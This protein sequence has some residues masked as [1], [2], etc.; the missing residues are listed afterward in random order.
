[1]DALRRRFQPNT[2]LTLIFLLALAT[3][4][5]WAQEGFN[6]ADHYNKYEYQVPMRDGVKLFTSVYAPKDDSRSYPI[7]LTRTPY[8]VAPYGADAYRSLGPHEGFARDGF[9]F[10]YQDV[11]GQFMSEGEFVHV[12]PHLA[13]KQGPADIDESTDT[14]DTVEW[15]IRSIPNNNGKVGIYGISYPGFYTAAGIIDT[16]PAIKAASPQAP[17][18]DWFVGDDFH[19]HGAFFLQDAF[20]FMWS[21]GRL[22]T[23]LTKSF[24]P[25]FEYPTQD[26]Y[27][28]FLEMGPLAQADKKYLK[29]EVPFWNE[30]MEHGRYDE[31]WQQ[32]NIIPHLKNVRTAVMTVAGWFDAEDP[33]GPLE[34]YHSIE[35]NN[36]G[37]T[38]ILVVGPWSHGGWVRS[39]GDALGNVRF[40]VKTG[41]D[42]REKI[43][44]PFFRYHLKGEGEFESPE[45]LVFITGTN[46]WRSFEAWPPAGAARKSLYLQRAEALSFEPPSDTSPEAFDAYPSDPD[47]PVPYTS[48]IRI[49][50]SIEYMVEDQRFAS[51]RPDVLVY[52]SEELSSDV[53]V[54]GPV[55]ADLYVS[56]TATDADFVVKLID[57]YPEDFPEIEP[58][59]KY[60]NVPMG[61]YEMLV[62]GEVMRARFRNSYENPEALGP[63]EVSRVR[64]R[65]PDI[66][67]TFKRGHRIMVQIQSS[68]FPLV[69]R[70]PQKFV[71]IYRA[72][73]ADFQKAMHRIHRSAEFPSKLEVNLL[74]P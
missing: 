31:F 8:S 43:D 41:R 58:E 3:Q 26:A 30:M 68:W 5:L 42:Y 73:E 1:M 32:R 65:M 33:Y 74:E 19:H 47:K 11:R 10:V 7:M 40:H 66:A 21:M 14:Y 29:G 63:G 35:K 34:I 37:I 70:N 2:G 18:G 12:R 54:V 23:E 52:Q 39:D 45:A 53:T 69:D 22:R 71:D 67:H 55:T 20:N 24:H 61:G 51:R 49:A 13:Q 57:V 16:H 17:V 15:L 59:E 50:R 28:F 62:R 27:K 44:L 72:S 25:R 48:E 56:S 9:I 36:P 64:F 46:A 38:N 6:T 4:P 60:L